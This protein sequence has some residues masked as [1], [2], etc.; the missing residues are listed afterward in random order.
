MVNGITK[1]SKQ[2]LI[3]FNRS[4]GTSWTFG[5]NLTTKKQSLKHSLI[6]ISFQN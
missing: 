3:E 2:A 5:G 1:A 4:H 6:N